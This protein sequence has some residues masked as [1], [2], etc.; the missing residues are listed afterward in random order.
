[1]KQSTSKQTFHEVLEKENHSKE[2][3]YKDAKAS[4]ENLF[5]EEQN[6]DKKVLV[7]LTKRE[8]KSINLK[9]KKQT[10]QSRDDKGTNKAWIGCTGQD[11]QGK[12]RGKHMYTPEETG[13]N[14]HYQRETQEERVS[15]HK[16]R[17]VG[18]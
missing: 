6:W 10:W 18:F 17:G 7:A 14:N 1:M 9:K 15:W 13:E 8:K 2:E 3:K 4:K 12:G 11:E 16:R 5:F